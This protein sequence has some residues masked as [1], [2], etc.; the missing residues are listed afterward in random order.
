[1]DGGVINALPSCL[2]RV[3]PDWN[4]GLGTGLKR[5]AQRRRD[6]RGV[7]KIEK[8][9]LGLGVEAAGQARYWDIAL[10]TGFWIPAPL[11]EEHE[12]L[13]LPRVM[14]SFFWGGGSF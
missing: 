11:W 8:S 12:L 3:V 7:R 5:R 4:Q 9:C 13:I 10:F 1:M 14:G 2:A 6:R